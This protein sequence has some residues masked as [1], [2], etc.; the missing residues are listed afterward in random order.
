MQLV[1]AGEP[2]NPQELPG[3]AC[4]A[5]SLG[6]GVWALTAAIWQTLYAKFEWRTVEV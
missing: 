1:V 6:P 2:G 5:G 3:S 4:Y